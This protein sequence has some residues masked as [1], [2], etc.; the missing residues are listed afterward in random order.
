MGHHQKTQ[1]IETGMISHQNDRK[2]EARKD[3]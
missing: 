2:G 3:Q 1:H